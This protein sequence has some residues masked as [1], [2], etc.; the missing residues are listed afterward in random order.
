MSTKNLKKNLG[1]IDVI[2]ISTGAMFSSGFFLL[3]G[4]A[5]A[6]TGASVFLAYLAAG[7]L[8]IP[9]MLSQA[10][11][12]TAMPKAGGTYFYLDRALGPLIGTIAGLGSFIA[13][14]LKTAFA[15]IGFGA[16]L[17]LYIETPPIAIALGLTLL[18]FLIN[19]FG[20]KESGKLQNILVGALITTLIIFIIEGLR[21][22]IGLPS[23][24]ITQRLT[25]F[26]NQSASGFFYTIAFV[27][28]SY[29][30]LTK[31]ASLAEEVKNAE[32][33]IPLGM[34]LSLIIT[35]TIYVIGVLIVVLLLPAEQLM[36]DLK[37]IASAT[38]YAF[39]W[40]DPKYSTLLITIAA[41]SAFASTGNAGVFAASRY[42]LAMARDKLL[43][44][45]L[46]RVNKFGIP[47]TALILTA[48][49]MGI[50]IAFL[51]IKNMVKIASAFQLLLFGLMN[52]AVI[53]MRE[54]K[55]KT[56]DPGFKSPL[57]PWVQFAGVLISAALLIYMG[58]SM[59]LGVILAVSLFS[60]W[61]W[62]YARKRVVR[63]G[64]IYHWFHELGKK[65]TNR[66]E[67]ELWEIMQEKGTRKQDPFE[68]TVQNAQITLK[69]GG[70]E[71][72]DITKVLKKN[73][74]L[75]QELLETTLQEGDFFASHGICCIDLHQDKTND[76]QLYI[77]QSSTEI[78]FKIPKKIYKK[79]F[80]KQPIKVLFLLIAPK[81]QPRMHLRLMAELIRRVEN[82]AFSESVKSLRDEKNL[83][84]LIIDQTQLIYIALDQ[85]SD[86]K[87]WIGKS[88]TELSLPHDAYISYLRRNGEDLIPTG[89]I[90]LRKNDEL[91]MIAGLEYLSND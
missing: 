1:L 77:F 78:K 33:N 71:F 74:H 21:T 8:V 23:E 69:D 57:Y 91:I 18:F 45:I 42:P 86:Y 17:K 55:I 27:F 24:V 20:A 6:Y 35:T 75:N 52:V 40:I 53:V 4:I 22:T 79:S 32:K 84:Q 15:L 87:D 89:A 62:A 66:L 88:I 25:P 65:H 5:Y 2:S 82:P 51:D 68:E 37:P 16:Y 43:P 19:Y 56:Y 46:Q 60:A 13:L 11:L 39:N 49:L 41:L 58:S 34:A 61:Y 90:T 7:I 28:V 76:A 85:K 63:H 38:H 50:L 3:P 72:T 26:F 73:K 67:E 36:S 64:A 81:S 14:I 12:A 59:I 80:G 48:G 30:G 83:R 70:V 9:A 31:V 44:D 10:E 54:S 29:A 47:G